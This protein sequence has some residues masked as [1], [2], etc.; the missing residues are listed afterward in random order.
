[1]ISERNRSML[2][3]ALCCTI[4]AILIYF[5]RWINDYYYGSLWRLSYLGYYYGYRGDLPSSPPCWCSAGWR[6]WRC[7]GGTPG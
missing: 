6:R 5:F 2:I 3:G 4:G 7:W 1:M